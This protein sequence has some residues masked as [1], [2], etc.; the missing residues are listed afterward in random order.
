MLSLHNEV[1]KLSSQEKKIIALSSLGGALEFYDFVIYMLFAP[2]LAAVF[3]PAADKLAMLLE[4]YA[5]FAIGYFIRPLG[6]LVF[7]HFGDRYG[8][9]TTF[10]AS[11]LLMSL[12]TGLIACLPIYQQAGILAPL[13]LIFLRLIQGFSVGGEIPGAIVYT[14]EQVGLN[15]GLACGVIFACFN[16]GI[17]TAGLI[18]LL[19]LNV[20]SQQQ[21]LV[22]GWRIPFLVGGLLGVLGFYLRKKMTESPLFLSFQQQTKKRRLPILEVIK[23]WPSLIRGILLTWLGA[24]VINLLFLYMPT[25]LSLVLSYPASHAAM[26]NSLNLLIYGGLLILVGWLSD[27]VGRKVVLMFGALGFILLGYFLFFELAQNT[28]RGLILAALVINVLSACVAVFPSVLVE[29]FATSVR[30]TGTAISY[31]LG[32]AMFGSLTPLIATYLIK[33]TAN[34]LAPSFYLIISAVACLIGLLLLEDK[35]RVQLNLGCKT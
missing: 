32:F 27:R 20:L 10:V 19:L 7:S 29:L 14:C 11:V 13:L 18:N 6:G 9:K 23:F 5:V 12:A 21:L 8:R 2:A 15:R 35:H 4:V 31:N 16:L 30:Y 1:R 34:V 22:W 28:Q 24:V 3:F 26:F 25:Y 33:T 17:L